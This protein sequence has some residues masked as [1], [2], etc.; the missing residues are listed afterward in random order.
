[1]CLGLYGHPVFKGVL[2][3]T[4]ESQSVY[5]FTDTCSMHL[6]NL[7][8]RGSSIPCKKSVKITHILLN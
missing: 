3:G 6:N 2:A 5:Q 1:M 4:T 7:I 8:A